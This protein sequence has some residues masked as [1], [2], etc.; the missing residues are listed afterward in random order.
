LREK[1][2]KL[3]SL[4]GR[5][6]KAQREAKNELEGTSKKLEHALRE[7]DRLSGKVERL[8]N[9]PT[10]MDL[11]ADF[12]TNFDKALLSVGNTQSGGQDTAASPATPS[13]VAPAQSDAVVD[14]MLLQE[15]AESQTRVE[16]LE[17]LNAALLHRSSQME[18]QSKELQREKETAQQHLARLQLELRMAKMEADNATRAVQDKIQ[19]LQEMQLE[20][21]LVT[22]ASM[23]ANVRAK[24]GEEAARSVQTDREKVQQLQAQVQALQ[25]WALASAEAKRLSQER[26]RFLEMKL[27]ALEQNDGDKPGPSGERVLTSKA[28]SL[29]VGAGDVKPA[30]IELGEHA[31]SLQEHER[32]VLRWRFDITPGDLSVEYSILKG[33]CETAQKR[34]RADYLIKNRMVTGGAGGETEAAFAV[35]NSC[36]LLWSNEKSWVRPRTI[37]YFVDILAVKD[38]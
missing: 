33:R 25:E 21:D 8:A 37:K 19:S 18:S 4:L 27:K 6:A 13:I 22:K 29:V 9:R 10:H 26:V 17:S 15:L 11:L 2:S 32:I 14:S 7:I 35:Q 16:R 24:Q 28:S 36:T 38:T 30:V 34:L 5:S 20:I 31:H 1:V 12:E 23:D 3:K